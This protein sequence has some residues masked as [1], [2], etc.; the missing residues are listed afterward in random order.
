MPMPD[1]TKPVELGRPLVPPCQLTRLRFRPDGRVLAAAGC[2]G[3]VRRWDTSADA[4]TELPA[5]DGH[6][7]W[8]SGLVFSTSAL[9]TTDSWGRLTARD[10]DGRQLW[11]VETA[12][13][14]WARAVAVTADGNLLAT[15]GRDGFVRFW[16]ARTG[17]K[18]GEANATADV[19]SV[20]FAPD[21]KAVLAGDLFG[22]VREFEAPG[23]RA[24]RTFE[25]RELHR[26]DR[27]QDVG[28]VRCLLV[29][30]DGRTLVV[31]GAEPKTGGFVEC[32]PLMIA[33][34][35]PSGK[36]LWQWKGGAPAEGYVTDLAWHPGGYVVACTSGQ[37]G[38]GK[39]FFLKP[40]DAQPFFQVPK[41]NVHSVAVTAD[42]T[43]LA[44]ALTNANSAGNGRVRG[45]GGDYPQN[46]SPVQLWRLPS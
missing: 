16:D 45:Q 2:D 40:G 42:G 35:R 39:V 17:T 14:G 30:P 24:G 38:Q 5:L 7:G 25:A 46:H 1:P 19:L 23:G 11:T 6:N 12:H 13:A 28:G 22:V 27:V 31:G 29:T 43:K 37:P 26:L 33:F 36:R 32:T 44:A 3:K 8:V 20:G 9:V 21:G 10:A 18:T 34:D 41:P 15:G 4:P